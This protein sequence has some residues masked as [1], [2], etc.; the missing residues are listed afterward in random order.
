MCTFTYVHRY[1]AMLESKKESSQ[2]I[3]EIPEEV[4]AG[5]IGLN[6]QPRKPLKILFQKVGAAPR[7]PHAHKTAGWLP[8]Q[9]QRSLRMITGVPQWEQPGQSF[10]HPPPLARYQNQALRPGGK[11]SRGPWEGHLSV[12]ACEPHTRRS[13]PCP[14]RE[15]R[16][17]QTE[18]SRRRSERQ[19]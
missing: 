1:R 8:R 6:P 11:G 17:Q 12:N 4:K 14:K 15:Q 3:R 5:G 19:R 10:P 16:A 18:A 7:V 2:W 9:E 13:Q